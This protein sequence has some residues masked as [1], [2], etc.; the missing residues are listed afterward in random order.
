[1]TYFERLSSNPRLAGY[2]CLRHPDVK[3]GLTSRVAAQGWAASS[4]VLRLAD[5]VVPTQRVKGWID[6]ADAIKTEIME[7]PGRLQAAELELGELKGLPARLEAAEAEL[8]RYRRVLGPGDPEQVLSDDRFAAAGDIAAGVAHNINGILMALMGYASLLEYSLGSNTDEHNSVLEILKATDQLANIVKRITASGGKSTTERKPPI[9]MNE[10][11]KQA[12]MAYNDKAG[13]QNIRLTVDMS[14]EH[15][16]IKADDVEIVMSVSNL[17]ENAF[18]AI[19]DGREAGQPAGQIEV[20]LQNL[21]IDE[22]SCRTYHGLPSG[23]YVKL[24]VSDNGV[25]ISPEVLRK[26][27]TPFFTTHNIAE[28]MG[29]GLSVANGV[30]RKNKGRIF[31]YSV[32][33]EGSIFTV[34][35]PVFKEA[36]PAGDQYS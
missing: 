4:A 5:S 3:I 9:D 24:S 7:L 18:R 19:E 10:I 23:D 29:L 26:I 31:V 22:A 34:L 11:V 33:G 35:L 27:F 13:K 6:S 25:G 17:I 30:V 28:S 32:E 8:A 15:A 36:V 1:M 2:T 21:V 12:L 20:S 14:C 16:V